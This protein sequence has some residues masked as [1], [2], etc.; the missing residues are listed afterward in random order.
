MSLPRRDIV[1]GPVDPARNVAEPDP[2]SKK[3][4]LCE[5]MNNVLALNSRHEAG[6]VEFWRYYL[7]KFNNTQLASTEFAGF[8]A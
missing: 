8:H 5:S 7:P 2:P 6:E 1:P 4:S 3:P